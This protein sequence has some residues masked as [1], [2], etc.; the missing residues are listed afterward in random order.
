ME[1]WT[2]FEYLRWY[3]ISST[4]ISYLQCHSY[5]LASFVHT[6]VQVFSM[7]S[8]LF[9]ILLSY[10]TLYNTV[11][12]FWPVVIRAIFDE[13]IYYMSKRKSTLTGSR[14]ASVTDYES[15]NDI[16]R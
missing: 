12:T 1:D 15:Q 16:L 10:V 4:R 5:I 11:F 6:L 13:D 3:C 14:R 8:K 9:L 7:I 2:I